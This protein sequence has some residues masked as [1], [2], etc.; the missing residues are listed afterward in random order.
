MGI[1]KMKPTTR[2]DALQALASAAAVPAGLAALVPA[3]AAMP[4]SVRAAPAG[5]PVVA[6]I[7]AHKAAWAALLGVKRPYSRGRP[8]AKYQTARMEERSALLALLTTMPTTPTGVVAALRYVGHVE[9][10]DFGENSAMSNVRF[11]ARSTMHDM[12][13]HADH[14]AE[15]KPA[16][17]EY[18]GRLAEAL[19]G[20]LTT[21]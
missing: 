5:N 15:I 3:I 4:V 10:H 7:E 11:Y 16:V 6:L 17:D 2:R 9:V 19:A 21:A 20:M 1:C 13:A 8:T 12:Y 18:L 14:A